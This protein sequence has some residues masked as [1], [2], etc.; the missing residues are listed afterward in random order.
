MNFKQTAIKAAKAAGKIQ[1]RHRGKVTSLKD[2]DQ[3]NIVSEVD[4]KCEKAILSIIKKSFPEHAILSEECGYKKTRSD[5]KWIIDPLDGT[6][7]YLY[8][9]ELFGVLIALEYKK[10]IILGAM[11]LPFFNNL[12][13]AEKGKG[14]FCNGKRI[15]VSKRKNIKNC[16]LDYAG[17]LYDQTS[18]RLKLLKK[19]ISRIFTTRLVGAAVYTFSNI[20]R[21]ASDAYIGFNLK[22]WDV[23]AAFLL[24]KEAGGRIT[25]LKGNKCDH[26]A[27]NCIM[28]NGLLHNQIVKAIK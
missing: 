17:N 20:A 3:H 4:I 12:Y 16:L 13:F 2:K 9:L 18:M 22:S 8:G 19:L 1:L 14:A 5:Y 10:E 21:G 7:N 6:H 28:S 15:H 27:K 26:Y 25:D 11:Y 23:A 24:I